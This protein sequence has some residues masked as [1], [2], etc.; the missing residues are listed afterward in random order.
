MIKGI[1]EQL[2]IIKRGIVD[3]VSEEELI[4]KLKENRPLVIKLGVDPTSPDLHLGHSVVLNKLRAFQDLGHKAVLI[5]GDFTSQVGDPSGRDSTRPVLPQEKI[6]ENAKTYTQQAFKI[7]DKEKTEVRFNSEWLKKFMSFND[8]TLEFFSVAKNITISRLLERED[9]KNRIKQESP[10]SL[11]EVIYPIFQGYDSVTIKADVELG[12]QD[13]I[14]N[15]LVGR[16]LQKMYKI[17]PQVCITLPLLV[18]TDGV[19]KMSKSYKN[20]IAFNDIPDEMFG[21]VMSV[22]DE[23]MYSYYELL[24]DADMD[25][26]KKEHPMKAKKQLAMILVERFYSKEA[27]LKV[28]ENFERVFSSKEIP[29]NIEKFKLISPTKISQILVL[30]GGA[31][32]N[33]E[34][35]RLIESGAVRINGQKVE[36]DKIIEKGDFVLQCGKRYF[37][38]IV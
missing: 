1:V 10:I 25:E 9:F 21:K 7:L 24:T 15:L 22:S 14:F 13:Q 32:S 18:G 29:D 19:K 37:R 31:K 12:G 20:Y 3:L 23:L 28:R 16:D 35:R 36:S 11:L 30:T 17:K 33:N 6:I 34:A 5:I 4:E 8:N 26:I 2:K 38:K 27:A